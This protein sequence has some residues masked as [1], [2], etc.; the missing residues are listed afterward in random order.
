MRYDAVVVG[1][2]TGGYPGAIYLA[3]KGL[4][5]AVVEEH[6]IGGECTNYGCVP[7]KAFYQ[8]AEAIRSIEK[9]GGEASVKWESLV[10]WV[11]QVVRESREGIKGLFESHGIDVI[12][13]RA[14][15]KTQREIVISAGEEKKLIEAGKILL[16]LGTD[17]SPIPGVSFDG[18]GIISNREALYMR[19][20]PSEVLIIG[21][22]VIGVELANIFSS[23]KVGVTVVE[24]MDHI[25]PTMD[26]DVA[27][28][29]KTHLSSR[30]VKIYEKTTVKSVTK[31]GSKYLVE[32]SNGLKLEVDK[33]LI[34]TGRKPRTREAGL[35]ENNIVLDQ[36][37]FIKINERQETSIPGIYAS[38]DVVG[39]PLLAHKAILESIS[40]ARWMSGEEGFH[41]DYS[42]IPSTI[43]TGL[44][45]AS[46]GYT[47]K[48]LTSKGVKY[49]K[50]RIPAYYLSAVK[51]KG[52]KQSFI[53]VLL[54][55]RQE[56]ILG[57]HIVAPNA[58]EVIS[59]YIPL[60]LGKIGFGDASRIPYP[61]LTVSESLRDLAEYLLGNPVHLLRK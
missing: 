35:I 37:G 4:K 13:G 60:Y 9:T 22:G 19:E 28:A 55:E 33:V 43:F 23:F 56:K 40:A 16:A 53:K 15:L 11:S 27:Q 45:I 44:E 31:T 25:L 10:E 41:I 26:R 2:G 29:L 14:I 49:V 6:L 34:A 48:E 42:A 18:E 59:A 58:S 51:I 17:P 20:K 21:G 7:S 32:L 39:G 24:L 61:H 57:V 30:G 12:E 8:V 38:G 5:I 52:G 36:K 50:V 54:D 3:Q 46:I 1:S 47:E